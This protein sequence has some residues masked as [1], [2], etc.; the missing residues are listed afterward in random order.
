MP[1]RSTV[2][3][4]ELTVANR[5]I[6]CLTADGQPRVMDLSQASGPDEWPESVYFR[7]VFEVLERIQS[8]GDF[9]FYLTN[10]VQRLPSY[11]ADVAVIVVGDDHCRIP[12]YLHKVAA[13]FKNCGNRPRLGCHPI[14]EPSFVNLLSLLVFGRRCLKYLPGLAY[15][16]RGL[17][18][19]GRLR[20][21]PL[22]EIPLGTANQTIVPMRQFAHRA[23]TLFFAG[24]V[25]HAFLPSRLTA[26][27]DILSPKR[28]ARV[29]MLRNLNAISDRH[30]NLGVEVSVAADYSEAIHGDGRSY[31]EELMD[32]RIALVPR[33]ACPQTFRFFQAMRAGVRG[34]H[35]R[36]PGT[37][38]LHG[39]PRGTR[40]ELERPR[41]R[42]AVT[43]GRSCAARAAPPT[44][45]RV[46]VEVLLRGGGRRVHRRRARRRLT[47]P[48]G[49]SAVDS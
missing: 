43:A 16:A 12:M 25:T 39:L 49:P 3:P 1:R 38:L 32:A 28:A 29:A 18:S 8:D 33:G 36:G 20:F 27:K 17:L 4:G 21:A 37:A 48:A 14:R 47:R 31:S 45:A 42:R 22:C 7:R 9:T 2:A 6:N 30:P 5:Y 35:R 41:R 23:S 10:D 46:V 19:G 44:G 34:D 24:S 13:V 26:I 15:Y 11:G 40:E